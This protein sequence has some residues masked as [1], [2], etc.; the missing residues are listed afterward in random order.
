VS[1]IDITSHL[2]DLYCYYDYFLFVVLFYK[3]NFLNNFHPFVFVNKKRMRIVQE[4]TLE[5]LNHMKID[6]IHL[7]RK[8]KND[9]SQMQSRC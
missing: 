9:L 7:K 2:A 3:T 4:M 6:L 1:E 8:K 5:D